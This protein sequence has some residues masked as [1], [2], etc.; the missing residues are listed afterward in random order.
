MPAPKTFYAKALCPLCH[1]ETWQTRGK[2]VFVDGKWSEKR[3]CAAC[4]GNYEYEPV[5]VGWRIPAP[6]QKGRL[7]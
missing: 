4:K 2:V 1:V 6:A 3:T 5:S 7:W